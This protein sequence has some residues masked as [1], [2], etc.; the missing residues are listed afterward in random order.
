MQRKRRV[1]LPLAVEVIPS[2]FFTPAWPRWGSF[3]PS[4]A[5]SRSQ[6][7]NS[8]ILPLSLQDGPRLP[9]YEC[10]MRRAGRWAGVL[11]HVPPRCQREMWLCLRG[12]SFLPGGERRKR[13]MKTQ[14]E[15][16]KDVTAYGFN[17]SGDQPPGESMCLLSFYGWRWRWLTLK[18]I[19][20][21][22]YLYF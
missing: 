17:S 15:R 3:A 12:P 11:R 2:A 7:E 18:E 8:L 19:N 10:L 21:Q 9:A 13:E 14:F 1:N 16:D 6:C 20:S 4:P 5:P 22:Y